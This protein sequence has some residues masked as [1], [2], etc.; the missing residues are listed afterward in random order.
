LHQVELEHKIEELRR[1]REELELS[2]NKYALLYDFA[3]VGYFT[4]NM[5]GVIQSVNLFGVRLLGVEIEQV[6]SQRFEE[7]VAY[8]DI[9]VFGNFIQKVFSGGRKETCRLRL[10]SASSSPLYVRI[11]AMLTASGD[12][13]LVV[14]VDITEKKMAEKALSESEY[15][16]SKAQAMTH[17]G[18]WSFNPLTGDIKASDELLRIMRLSRENTTQEAFAG[19]VHPDDRVV[20]LEHLRMGTE[21][22][23]NYEIEHRLQFSDGSSRWVYTIVEPQV[24]SLGQVTKLYGTPSRQR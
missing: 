6:I 17:V 10:S 9:Y 1:S 11:E 22:G 13:C 15:N 3:P 4:L 5:K 23:M 24:N 12:E 16:L 7:F 2:R 18:S 21:H 19:V 14:L 20:V 8:E